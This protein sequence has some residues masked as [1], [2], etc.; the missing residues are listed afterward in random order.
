MDTSKHVALTKVGDHITVRVVR[1]SPNE[2]ITCNRNCACLEE[3][4]NGSIQCSIG[5]IKNMVNFQ[6]KA[7]I[8]DYEIIID[9][10]SEDEWSVHAA[11]FP[12]IDEN[13]N[14]YIGE[15]ICSDIVSHDPLSDEQS[16]MYPGTRASF[17]VY[18]ETF[19]KD[20]KVS[21]IIVE[22]SSYLQSRIDLL[23]ATLPEVE[24]EEGKQVDA[25]LFQPQDDL[26]ERVEALEKEVADLRRLVRSLTE[27]RA[28][29]EI[30]QNNP[31]RPMSDPGIG[32][33]PLDN[34]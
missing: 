17:R 26:R 21:S 33:H 14:I 5:W 28:S 8:I 12:I 13:G 9:R 32:Y 22:C 19:P 29:K 20:G 16:H 1:I 18:Y 2:V 30:S 7:L 25:V 11:D 31:N 15:F 6:T 3:S 34:K 4:R 10:K 27:V 24:F 23:P